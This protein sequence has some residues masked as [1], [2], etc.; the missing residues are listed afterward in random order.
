MHPPALWLLF[1]SFGAS[2]LLVHFYEWQ[3]CAARCSQRQQRQAA[4][5][6]AGEADAE[7]G[8][9]SRASSFDGI[10]SPRL[11]PAGSYASPP[12]GQEQRQQLLRAPAQ[13][14][15]TLEVSTSS[16]D[17][18]DSGPG[19]APGL[20]QP[21]TLEAQPR[22]GWIDWARYAV[23]RQAL[24]GAA[25][26]AA[27]LARACPAGVVSASLAWIQQPARHPTP[28]CARRHY[29]DALLVAVVGLSALE[30]DAVH[31]VYLA[32]ALFLFRSRIALRA[33]R[34]RWAW[35]AGEGLQPVPMCLRACGWMW[36]GGLQG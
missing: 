2:T 5:A 12:V 21:L 20:W 6:A 3:R 13:G 28:T 1:L 26:D 32:T 4:A 33:R 22:W 29:L 31:A 25:F 11:T 14:H 27:W 8:Q 9:L 16:A 17:L 19:P 34:N 30:N 7:A 35:R 23:Y 10:E 15:T 18:L 24:W 36:G